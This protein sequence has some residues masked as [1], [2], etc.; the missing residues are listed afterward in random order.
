MT[1]A[2]AHEEVQTIV[3]AWG[4]AEDL[5]SAAQVLA[6]GRRA[7]AAVLTAQL[8]EE[9]ADVSVALMLEAVEAED[10]SPTAD[11]ELAGVALSAAQAGRLSVWSEDQRVTAHALGMEPAA[12]CKH[13]EAAITRA[14]AGDS[15]VPA[16]RCDVD[17]ARRL[18][19]QVRHRFEKRPAPSESARAGLT[20]LLAVRAFKK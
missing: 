2:T 20:G 7:L 5:P 3:L 9:V 10:E 13:L 15:D 4:V 19:G 16:E 18:L 14:F 11:V 1:R 8:V 17:E 12:W 6:E